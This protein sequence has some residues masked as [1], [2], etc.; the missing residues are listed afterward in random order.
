MNKKTNLIIPGIF[1]LTLLL[2]SCGD[3][4]N[5]TPASS[6]TG[7]G[8]DTGGG[9]A[10]L[11]YLN[12]ANSNAAIALAASSS[13]PTSLPV[14]IGNKN[15]I[16]NFYQANGI[17]TGAS[18]PFT[19]KLTNN[20]TVALTASAT[21]SVEIS[22]TTVYTGPGDVTY[23]LTTPPTFPVAAGASTTFTVTLNNSNNSFCAFGG[24]SIGDAATSTN[25]EMIVHTN[26]PTNANY[27]VDFT[28]LGSS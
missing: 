19:F 5:T 6:G 2:A 23:T 14:S 17:C 7:A 9:T 12:V 28:V 3:D 8:T 26:D 22:D 25:F 18:I 20:G 27:L 11:S 15:T 21:P 13:F 10:A 16:G 4:N 1:A 24:A